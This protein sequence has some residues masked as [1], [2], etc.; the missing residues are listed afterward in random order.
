MKKTAFTAL[1][2]L[3]GS[4]PFCLFSLSSTSAQAREHEKITI[5]GYDG[6]PIS[7]DGRLP[8]SPRRTCGACHDYGRITNAYHF[9]QGRTDRTGKIVISDTFDPKYPWNLSSGMFGKY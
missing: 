1:F 3:L 7:V 2:I 5:R 6:A 8:Y 9:Q 4:F